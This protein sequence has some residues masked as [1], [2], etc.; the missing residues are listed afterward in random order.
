MGCGSIVRSRS[1]LRSSPLS[2][3]PV[4]LYCHSH[5]QAG[6]VL[7]NVAGVYIVGEV[8]NGNPTYVCPYQQYMSGVLN[9]PM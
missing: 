6:S 9:Y 1:T 3:L 4:C 2:N 5:S 8:F 7:T